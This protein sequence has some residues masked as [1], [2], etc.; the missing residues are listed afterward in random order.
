MFKNHPK[1]V[2]IKKDQKNDIL[3]SET[4]VASDFFAKE[5]ESLAPL[6]V[7]QKPLEQDNRN[8]NYK[9]SGIFSRIGKLLFGGEVA[10]LG[11]QLELKPEFLSKEKSPSSPSKPIVSKFAQDEKTQFFVN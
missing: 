11:D 2:T 9:I 8:G 5:D 1:S 4:N 7:M 6:R 3:P 10:D